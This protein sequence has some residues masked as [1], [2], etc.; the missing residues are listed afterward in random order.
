MSAPAFVTVDTAGTPCAHETAAGAIETHARDIGG[1]WTLFG[2]RRDEVTPD[3]ETR[4]AHLFFWHRDGES[5]PLAAAVFDNRAAGL[6]LAAY[7]NQH[8]R[9]H[10]LSLA[11]LD[12]ARAAWEGRDGPRV[13]DY[14]RETGGGFSRF[15][16]DTGTGLQAGG[17]RGSFHISRGGFA[18]YS[19]GLSASIPR[20]R[21]HGTGETMN[22]EFWFFLDGFAGAHRGI[23]V[24][25]PCRI[26][27]ESDA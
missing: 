21:L 16:N 24:Q 19:G 13:G 18:S 9:G 4:G 7:L 15:T 17:G 5:S 2:G 8:L 10:R 6:P 27:Q 26:Y 14:V 22:G 1:N 23:S 25:M 3:L 20:D 12:A 11:Y